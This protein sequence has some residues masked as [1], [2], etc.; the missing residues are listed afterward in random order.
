MKVNRII[1]TL[2]MSCI[3]LSGCS[4]NPKQVEETWAIVQEKVASFSDA[5]NVDLWRSD[6]GGRDVYK[7]SDGTTLLIVQDASGPSNVYVGGVEDFYDMSEAAQKA[8]LTYYE[9][10]GLLYDIQTE[11]KKA[12]DEYLICKKA[13][14]KFNSFFISQAIS[15]ASSNDRI[16]CFLTAVTLPLGEQRAQEI[17]LG[18]VFDKETGEKISA[19][20]LF[21]LSESESKKQLLDAAQIT[22]TALM[23]EMESTL[24]AEYIILFPDNLDIVFP[25]GVLPSQEH[26]YIIGIDYADLQGIVKNSAIPYSAK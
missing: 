9:E 4:S 10:Q 1:A 12:Y 20:D 26:S 3:F 13:G 14:Q 11:L 5:E 2:L 8:V 21:S 23:A 25:P 15:P 22:D 19:W 7:L 18:A 6:Y 16:M 17:H 24:K